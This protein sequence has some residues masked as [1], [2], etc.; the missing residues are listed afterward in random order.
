MC[1]ALYAAMYRP[2]T[3]FGYLRPCTVARAL[4]QW[5]HVSNPV[6]P[7]FFSIWQQQNAAQPNACVEINACSFILRIY[8]KKKKKNIASQKNPTISFVH[9]LYCFLDE[10]RKIVRTRFVSFYERSIPQGVPVYTRWPCDFAR[11]APE[12]APAADTGT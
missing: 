6:A 9:F 12:A 4:V 3:R 1:S 8:S 11:S 5:S 10:K 7:L 2:E